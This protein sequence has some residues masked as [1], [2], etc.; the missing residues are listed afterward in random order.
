MTRII[1]IALTA[2]LA[3]LALSACGKPCDAHD[4]TIDGYCNGTTAMNCRQDCA[5]CIDVW[6]EKACATTC[7]VV[8]QKPAEGVLDKPEPAMGQPTKWAVCQ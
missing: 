5:D 3:A 8:S 7:E 6:V 1:A 4:G 2:V